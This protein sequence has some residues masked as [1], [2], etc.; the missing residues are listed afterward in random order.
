MF[1]SFWYKALIKLM[2]AAEK[3]GI[4][5]LKVGY[6]TFFGIT[7]TLSVSPAL[8]DPRLKFLSVYKGALPFVKTLVNPQT[9]SSKRFGV[10]TLKKEN[11][12]RKIL[13]NNESNEKLIIISD[14]LDMEIRELAKDHI[15][16]AHR[17]YHRDRIKENTRKGILNSLLIPGV[18]GAEYDVRETK[19]KNSSVGEF[20]LSHDRT[21]RRVFG[22]PRSI[23]DYSVEELKRL[24]Q[25]E[26]TTLDELIKGYI[27]LQREIALQQGILDNNINSFN[28]KIK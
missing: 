14:N 23:D 4:N 10:W 21:L 17:G 28:P 15:L 26:F 2:E 7:G 9:L 13:E 18:N 3:L 8:N 16:I 5:N 11:E 6:L 24:T 22:V 12:L 27:F 1:Q 25:N 19:P 20:V